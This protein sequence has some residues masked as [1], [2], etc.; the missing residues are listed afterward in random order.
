MALSTEQF[1]EKIKNLMDNFSN[2][3]DIV[4]LQLSEDTKDSI[5]QRIQQKGLNFNNAPFEDYTTIY[6]AVKQRMGKYSGKVDL[7]LSGEM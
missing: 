6:K 7:T 5:V 4:L 1:L 2:E 3:L